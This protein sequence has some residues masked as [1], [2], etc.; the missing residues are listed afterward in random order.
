[1]IGYVAD[2]DGDF[3]PG[4]AQEEEENASEEGALRPTGTL[5]AVVL[6]LRHDLKAAVVL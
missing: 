1:M 4:Q 6:V 2:S 3:V 5:V